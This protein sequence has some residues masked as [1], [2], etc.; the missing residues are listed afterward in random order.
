MHKLNRKSALFFLFCCVVLSGSSAV[1]A[2]QWPSVH[3]LLV[4]T[5]HI[6][7]AKLVS[8]AALASPPEASVDYRLATW[9]DSSNP[10][11]YLG[12]AQCE[13]TAGQPDAAL[14][15]LK[16]AGQGSDATRL[17][18]R[19]LI[20]LGRT[21]EAADKA[22]VLSAPGN[23]DPD[24]ILAG[25]A[26]ALAQR[27][28]EIPALI[29]SVSSP[30]AATRLERT[31]IGNIALADELY[32]SGLPESSKR[33]LI[34][35]PTSFERNLLLA[36]INY[37]Q[38]SSTELSSAA[39]Y[40]VSAIAINPQSADAHLLLADVYADTG[41]AQESSVQKVLAQDITDGKP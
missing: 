15:I 7:A 13:I 2:N 1:L 30:Q 19:T 8:Q 32:L 22:S 34:K 17:G 14:S 3:R 37:T 25:L 4:S 28:Q 35:L 6:E 18:I 29:A 27:P 38:H 24:L 10:A 20:E 21:N 36:R 33:L 5:A 26:Y 39:D 40:L 31:Q 12:L 9:L 23:T 41:H 11:G 16:N